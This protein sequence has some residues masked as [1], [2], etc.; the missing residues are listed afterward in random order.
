MEPRSLLLHRRLVVLLVFL[1][2]CCSQQI[3]A[4][5]TPA[6]F[7]VATVK[8]APPNADPST[9]SWSPPGIGRFW[10]TH[11]SLA[12]LIH[13]AYGVDESQIANKRGWLETNLYD[14]DAKP[15]PGIQL[16]RDE[17]RPRLQELLRQR[18]RLAVHTETRLTLGYA[19]VV[20]KSGP[21]L[22]PS[23]A[24]KFPGFR[25]NVSPGE[26]R[27]I[28]WSMPQ[29]AKY[30]TP[31]AGFP[32]VDQTGI[33]GNYDIGFSYNPNP[34]TNSPLPALNEALTEATG[35]SLKPQKVPVEVLVIDSVN[36]VPAAN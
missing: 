16:S 12:L 32:V 10:A 35:L 18:F 21:R 20:P 6:S 15:E 25:T 28:N 4:Q 30:L 2:H 23:K 9:G 5:S 36:K 17:L 8:P 13:L 29:L 7:E 34:D 14:I 33:P 19:L 22:I 31:A 1:C 3:H 11:V 27:G 26:M 24:D